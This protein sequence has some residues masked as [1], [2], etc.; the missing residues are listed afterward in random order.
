MK[1]EAGMQ[2]RSWPRVGQVLALETPLVISALSPLSAQLA[3]IEAHAPQTP[4]ERW[5]G[6][7]GIAPSELATSCAAFE[8]LEVV[9]GPQLQVEAVEI[10]SEADG[11]TLMAELSQMGLLANADPLDGEA[12]S[13]P[14]VA[15]SPS[16]VTEEIPQISWGVKRRPHRIHSGLSLW[17]RPETPSLAQRLAQAQPLRESEDH[18]ALLRET[19]RP[20]LMVLAQ[21]QA[22]AGRA[23]LSTPEQIHWAG[24]EVRVIAPGLQALYGHTQLIAQGFAA[25]ELREQLSLRGDLRVDVFFMGVV[26]YRLL[27][28]QP[29]QEEAS[30]LH[31]GL[32]AA[33]IFC[34]SLH[35]LIEA[36]LR[37]A[38]NPLPQRRYESLHAMHESLQA[39]LAGEAQAAASQSALYLDVGH[40][41]HIGVLKRLMMPVNQDALFVGYEPLQQRGLFVLSD[42][43]SL[44]SYGS[45]ELASGCV[46]EEAGLLWKRLQ[47][48]SAPN[49]GISAQGAEMQRRHLLVELVNRANVAIGQ[50]VWSLGHRLHQSPQGVMAATA[51]AALIE[52]DRATLLSLGDSSAY[53]LRGGLLGRVFAPHNLGNYMLQQGASPAAVAQRTDAGALVR[54]VGEFELGVKG[55][56]RPMPLQPDLQGIRLRSGDCLILCSDGLTDYAGGTLMQAEW[57]IQT[58]LAQN[59]D[60]RWTAFELMVLAN[61][62]GGGDNISCIVLRVHEA[63]PRG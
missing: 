60:A 6:V 39:I 49:A 53:L 38:L 45:G 62:G 47:A 8:N 9:Q 55:R 43:V 56:L 11:P 59:E 30:L 33:Q 5:I 21:L 37:R 1:G 23:V 29:A 52:G 34:P 24:D 36:M 25:P 7:L 32:P 3:W 17:R 22:R 46:R 40:E 51:V 18:W 61:R 20:L 27:T 41:S 10:L 63:G 19:F 28:G 26:L 42:G 50:K 48:R 2:I 16:A 57:R 15:P 14:D 54:C 31:E 35:P 44:S 12:H 13:A 4:E 58:L